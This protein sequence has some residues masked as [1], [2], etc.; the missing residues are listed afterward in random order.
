GKSL[1]ELGMTQERPVPGYFVKA[2]VFP[3]NKFPGVDTLLGPEMRSTGEVMG[4]SSS[5]G[6]AFAKAMLA[7]GQR[8]PVAGTV[9]LSVN[10]Y[11]KPG[12]VPIAAGLYEMGFKLI[13][14]RGTASFL[15]EAGIKVE[16]VNKVY[17]G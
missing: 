10:S 3:F 1:R 4:L 9:F 12:V 13:A 6:N 14:T 5:F 15:G 16:A 8:L 7:A 17:E 11:D 2:V